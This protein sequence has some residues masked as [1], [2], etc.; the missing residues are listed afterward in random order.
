MTHPNHW[1]RVEIPLHA[2]VQHD[3]VEKIIIVTES[4]H[5]MCTRVTS[6]TAANDVKIDAVTTQR[7]VNLDQTLAT[8]DKQMLDFDLT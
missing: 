3:A 1:L 2:V 8:I 6:G 4:A 5:A 7:H